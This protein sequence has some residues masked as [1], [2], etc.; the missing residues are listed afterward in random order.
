[1]GAADDWARIEGELPPTWSEAQ[2]SVHVEEPSR[3]VEVASLLGPLQPGRTPEG[4]RVHVRNATGNGGLEHAQRMFRKLDDARVWSSLALVDTQLSEAPAAEPE[5][6]VSL[7]ESWDEAVAS[8]P[9]DWSDAL[10]ELELDSSDFIARAALLCA[11]LNPTRVPEELALRFRASG[12][13]GYG[14]AAVMVRRCLERCDAEG[15]TGRVRLLRSL[16]DADNVATQG[17]VWRIAGKP[18]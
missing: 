15:I 4:L 16:A 14:A 3:I 5:V 2:L 10:L 12:K 9:P 13:A 7:A 11:P 8:L 6:A 17:P 18:V 1:M